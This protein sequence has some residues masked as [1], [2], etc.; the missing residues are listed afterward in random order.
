VLALVAYLAAGIAVAVRVG[1]VPA[2][3]NG[4][5][6]RPAQIASEVALAAVL[7][8]FVVN[9]RWQT[10]GRPRR[11]RPRHVADVTE[12]PGVVVAGEPSE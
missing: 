11:G 5:F 7:S 3:Q 12:E 6:G 4:A 8:A 9:G 1:T 2:N 10:R